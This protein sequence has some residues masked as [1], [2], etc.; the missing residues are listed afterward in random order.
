MSLSLLTFYELKRMKKYIF[1]LALISIGTVYGQ[2]RIFTYADQSNTLGKGQKDVEVGTTLFSGKEN[3]FFGVEHAADFGLGLSDRIQGSFGLS[4]DYANGIDNLNGKQSYFSTHT[5]SFSTGLT[6]RLS[7][8]LTQRIGSAI[9]LGYTQGSTYTEF[10]GKV[11]L[12]KIMN[13]WVQAFNLMGEYEYYKTFTPIGD[14]IA[15]ER[16]AEIDIELNYAIAYKVVE[17]F[18]L[19]LEAMSQNHFSKSG[20]ETSVLTLGPALSYEV[21][22]NFIIN[23]TVMPQLTNLK[24]A[25]RELSENNKIMARFIL[26]LSL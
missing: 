8:I 5:Y 1:V 4:Y 15:I 7:D 14:L 16:I 11:I 20:W 10:Q 19:G 21:G 2:C 23:F 6:Y 26:C 9:Y 13:R 18:Y 12:D 17:G 25:K 22:G 3:Y 24:T